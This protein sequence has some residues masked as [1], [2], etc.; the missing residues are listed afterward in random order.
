MQ[1][2]W[3]ESVV[4]LM[5]DTCVYTVIRLNNDNFILIELNLPSEW[6]K[7]A[8]TTEDGIIV[9]RECVYVQVCVI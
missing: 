7:L 8:Q 6:E 9:R 5:L 3:N 1:A 2:V 4:Y